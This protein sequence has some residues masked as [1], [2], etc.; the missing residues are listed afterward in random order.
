M[1]RNLTLLTILGALIALAVPA[2]SMASMYPAAHKFEITGDANGPKLTTSLGSCSIAKITGTIPSAPKNEELGSFTIPTPTAGT[3]STGASMTLGSNWQFNAQGYFAIIIGAGSE[4]VVMRFASLPGCK[5]SGQVLF[6][7]IWSNGITTPTL[8][9]S[10]FHAHSRAGTLTWANDSGSCALAGKTE[11]LNAE[12]G[13]AS[14]TVTD[15]TSPTTP[16][17]I[18]NN[19]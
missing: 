7:G 5:L 8:L 1:K 16:V 13:G 9:K 17:L 12:S 14:E 2:S 18:G 11:T 15:L 19:K 3:C 6:T 10:G 4:G